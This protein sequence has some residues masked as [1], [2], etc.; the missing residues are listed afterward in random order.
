MKLAGAVLGCAGILA[1]KFHLTE[2]AMVALSG[3]TLFLLCGLVG[4]GVNDEVVA[5]D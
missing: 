4:S 5:D 1:A 2:G 3:G